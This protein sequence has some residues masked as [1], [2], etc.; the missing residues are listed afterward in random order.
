MSVV[1][2]I[3]GLYLGP[4]AVHLYRKSLAVSTRDSSVHHMHGAISRF[5]SAPPTL[6]QNLIAVFHCGAGCTLGDILAES[7]VPVI[8][9]AFAGA[10]GT[11]LIC[12]FVLA[13]LIGIAFQYV[14]I[15]PM[16]G[17]SFGQGLVAAARA[18]T[19]SI[20][21]FQ[22]GMY[23]WMALTY[24]VVFPA[25]H[26]HP[27]SA[28]FWFMMQIA[29]IVGTF[30]AL[31][32]NAWLIRKGWKEKMPLLDPSQAKFEAAPERRAA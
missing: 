12:D 32:A 15:A 11:K 27:G 7:L 6:L 1:W 18:D 17:L 8:G 4:V 5:E 30:T 29:M 2:P 20:T 21:L 22:V 23:A 31:P 13:W 25:P 9:L 24:F 16:R 26:L 3:T 10:F 14:T 28:V 19:I